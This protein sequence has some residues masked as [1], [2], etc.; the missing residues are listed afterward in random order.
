MIII[1]FFFNKI[2]DFVWNVYKVPKVT[3]LRIVCR[4]TESRIMIIGD[5]HRLEEL[6]KL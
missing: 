3:E 1:F 6:E 4:I 2:L 5:V